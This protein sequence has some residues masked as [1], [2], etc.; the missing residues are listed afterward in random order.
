M[1]SNGLSYELAAAAASYRKPGKST[2]LTL[3]VIAMTYLPIC[4]TD[5]GAGWL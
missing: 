5:Y 1:T 2:P 3:P 4:L